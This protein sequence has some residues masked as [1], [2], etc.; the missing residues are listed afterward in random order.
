MI[1]KLRCWLGLHRWDYP[2]D[3]SLHVRT[4]RRC[5]KMQVGAYDMC[6]G[7]TIWTDAA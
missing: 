7:G 5:K 6:Y 2:W 1:A 3:I 4:C